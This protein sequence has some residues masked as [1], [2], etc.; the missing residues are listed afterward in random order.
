MKF[1][2]AFG[3]GL[4]YI[5]LLP[6]LFVALAV[7]GLI[8]LGQW[9][10]AFFKGSI[11]FFKGDSFF[12]PLPEDQQVLAIK[13]EELRRKS[14]PPTPVTAP[15]SVPA[16]P[17]QVYIQQNYYQSPAPNAQMPQQN[18]VP[19]PNQAFGPSGNPLPNGN[20]GV[21]QMMPPNSIPPNIGYTIDPV[22]SV[23]PQIPNQT[24]KNDH[25]TPIG[26]ID[27]SGQDGDDDK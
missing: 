14:E 12:A 9:I 5:L 20:Y 24:P 25:P 6:L 27:I 18:Q 17:A 11:R 10:F 21:P 1:L 7:V 19:F 4:V 15:P 16:G 3:L 23:T 8:M 13:A 2:R 26:V 22:A